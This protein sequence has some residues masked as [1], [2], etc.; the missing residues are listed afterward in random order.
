MSVAY[1]MSA[2]YKWSDNAVASSWLDFVFSVTYAAWLAVVL[3]YAFDLN[4][5]LIVACG[6]IA[7]LSTMLVAASDWRRAVLLLPL[8]AL[9]GPIVRVNLWEGVWLNVADGMLIMLLAVKVLD[10]HGSLV[11][12]ILDRRSALWVPL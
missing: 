1:R 7:C 4:Q 12:I 9:I 3:T 2:S 5:S 6:S 8:V 10:S 11:R